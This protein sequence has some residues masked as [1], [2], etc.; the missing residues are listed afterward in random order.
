MNNKI[1]EPRTLYKSS[2]LSSK[3]AHWNSLFHETRE[4]LLLIVNELDAKALD[5]TIDERKVETIGTLL[6]HIA[7]IEWSWIFEDIDGLEL[8][9]EEWKEAFALRPQVDVPQIKGKNKQFYLEKLQEVREQVYQRLQEFEDNDLERIV[10]SEGNK[11]SI[12]W[13]LFHILEHETMHIGQILL[14]KRFYE[15]QIR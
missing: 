7:A 10:E 5:F 6:F 12:E 9:Y 1:D 4:R 3:V 15:K 2:G 14:L 13:I 8:D 11:Y